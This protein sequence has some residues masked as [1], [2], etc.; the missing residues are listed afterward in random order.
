VSYSKKGRT[1]FLM[2]QGYAEAHIRVDLPVDSYNGW[3]SFWGMEKKDMMGE[4]WVNC[5][6][7]D[8]LEMVD[9]K[10]KG[11][12]GE[13]GKDIIYTGT[14][15]E[16]KRTFDE[17]GEEIRKQRQ[18][19]SSSVIASGYMDNFDYIDDQ[20]HTYAALWTEGYIA[21][22]L[23]GELM[24]SVKFAENEYPTFYYRDIEEPLIWDEEAEPHLKGRTWEG[25]HSIMNTDSMV[26]FLGAH[27]TWPIEVD[28]VRVWEKGE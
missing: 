1:G 18:F 23:D 24:H 17:N 16:H 22:Y 9:P 14:L 5:G 7:L 10:G 21:W 4:F 8:I 11:R 25:A 19:A 27:E 12:S 28:W 13:A 3:P 2:T 20:W 6:E 26:L 15:H